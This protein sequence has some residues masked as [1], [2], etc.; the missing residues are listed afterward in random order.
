MKILVTGGAGFIGSHVVDGYVADGNEVIVIDNLSRGKKE[1]INTHAR[2]FQLDIRDP[3]IEEIFKSE[4]PEVVNHHAAQIDVRKSVEEP[5]CDAEANILGT[6]NLLQNCHKFQVKRILFASS[7]GA[8][9]GEQKMFPASEDHQVASLSPYGISKL[10]GENYLFYYKAVHNMSYLSL[11]YANVYGP[12]QDPYGE[13]GVVAIF[14]QK[15]LQGQQPVINGDGKQTRD[16]VYIDDVVEANRIALQNNYCGEI[17][18]GTGVE[19]TVNEIFKI[20]VEITET[21]ISETHGPPK[22]GEQRR[23]CLDCSLAEKVLGWRP[24]TELQEG[25]RRTVES[26]REK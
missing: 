1:N 6:I 3:K 19:T 23:S 15:L 18:I 21:D 20:L 7:G 4:M 16:Y 26:F 17:N 5:L 11:R 12:R 25:L 13:A 9:Y 14:A 22:P 10:A 24:K 8:I 2:F